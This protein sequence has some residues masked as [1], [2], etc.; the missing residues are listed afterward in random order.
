MQQTGRSGGGGQHR[1]TQWGRIDEVIRRKHVVEGEGGREN[2]RQTQEIVIQVDISMSD[3]SQDTGYH[4]YMVTKT[5]IPL[6]R[7]NSEKLHITLFT[8]L[9]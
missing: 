2:R 9:P 4:L 6:I 5:L 7:C 8:V 3:E 1:F